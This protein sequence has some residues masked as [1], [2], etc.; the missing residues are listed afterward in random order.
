MTLQANE[1]RVGNWVLWHGKPFQVDADFIRRAELINWQESDGTPCHPEPILLTGEILKMAGFE[2]NTFNQYSI[3][4]PKNTSRSN[5]KF[6]FTDDYLYLEEENIIAQKPTII[7]VW[8]KDLIKHFYLH[9]LQNVY[10][11]LSGEE[12]TVLL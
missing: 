5:K 4:I 3:N 12:L 6:F 11:C 10:M 2:K 9:K 1:L 7:T 8:N